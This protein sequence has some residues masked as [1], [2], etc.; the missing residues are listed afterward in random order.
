MRRCRIA[1]ALLV[2][3]TALAWMSG[4]TRRS[5]TEAA[6]AGEG[7]CEGCHIS[8]SLLKATA[9]G[10]G[11]AWER[12]LVSTDFVTSVHG[13][14]GC[15]KC[16]GGQST[17]GTKEEMH[18]GIA[19]DPSGAQRNVCAACHAHI[20]TVYNKSPH[21]SQSGF[22]AAILARSGLTELDENGRQ[23]L[24][25]QCGQCH[26]SCGQCHIARPEAAGGG[27]VAGH[28]LQHEPLEMENCLGCHGERL[29]AEFTGQLPGLEADVHYQKGMTCFDCHPEEGMHGDGVTYEHRY[30]VADLP[31]CADCH[32]D[33]LSEETS[34][35]Y[36]K[37]MAKDVQ[38]QVCHSSS[39]RN[40]YSCHV[41]KTSSGLRQEVELDFRIGKNPIQD[42]KHPWE[43]VVL[44]HV[45]IAPDSYQEWGLALNNYASKP[46]WVYAS[47]H[48]IQ[49]QTPQNAG[50]FGTCHNNPDVFLTPDYIQ[51]KVD[52]G[53][54]VQ[55]EV[56]AND[57]VVVR[58]VP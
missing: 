58:E 57:S 10:S 18:R 52:Q 3:V 47:P 22:V 55:A 25:Q 20:S 43:Y 21:G 35:I 15:Q 30:Q 53:L 1:I 34:N 36:H 8:A 19:L 32:P 39:Y 2:S 48:N 31:Q 38:C 26:A 6:D 37:L 5:P 49:R 33:A 27:L 28:V 17:P 41:G 46:T 44:R 40:C 11:P 4:C 13:R 56:Q 54:M 50:C 14:G 9:G 24:D 23:M 51:Q 29:G 12:Y 7:T 16:H 42:E 45:P